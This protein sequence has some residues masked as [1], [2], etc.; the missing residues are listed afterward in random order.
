MVD[1][2]KRA[3]TPKETV[4]SFIRALN[5]KDYEAARA[6]V[7]DRF[8]FRSPVMTIPNPDEYFTS[9][10]QLMIRYEIRKV[11]A[12]GEDVCVFYDY[13]MGGV[14]RFGCGWY[15]VEGGKIASLRILSDVPPG[16][17]P[18]GAK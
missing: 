9:M 15:R 2:M 5:G 18:S 7:A 14:A 1:D 12:D 6:H 13:T 17:P 8:S 4:L 3:P 16:A 11:F 10:K